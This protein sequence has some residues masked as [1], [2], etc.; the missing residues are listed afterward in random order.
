MTV[1]FDPNVLQSG[2]PATP[3]NPFGRIAINEIESPLLVQ[4]VAYWKRLAAGR[5]FPARSD[6]TP[7]SLG[8]LLR[9]TTL[10]RVVDG[11]SDYEYRIVGDAFVLAHGVSFQGRRWSEVGRLSPR[12]HR[13]IKPVY[14]SVVETREPLATRGWIERSAGTDEYIYCEYIYLPLGAAPSAVDHIL[15]FAVYIPHDTLD[16]SNLLA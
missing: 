3:T 6:V 15:I 14:D 12:F 1:T 2:P 13:M 4:A 16:R 7:R 8:P 10:L 5:V 9:Y 11:G